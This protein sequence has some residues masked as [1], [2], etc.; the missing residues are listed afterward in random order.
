MR[1]RPCLFGPWGRVSWWQ[2]ALENELRETFKPTDDTR[3]LMGLAP[4]PVSFGPEDG[5]LGP[6]CILYHFVMSFAF[7]V[8]AIQNS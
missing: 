3:R 5:R 4:L 2:G 1:G 8:S 7:S 6:T